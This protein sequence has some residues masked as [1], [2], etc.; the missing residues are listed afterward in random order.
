[1][2]QKSGTFTLNLFEHFLGCRANINVTIADINR[3]IIDSGYNILWR[4]TNT[5]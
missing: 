1:M 5:F 4:Y 2:D 3:F